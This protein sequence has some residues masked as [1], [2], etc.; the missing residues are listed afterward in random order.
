MSEVK[1]VY[2]VL[3]CIRTEEG[4]A[5]TPGLKVSDNDSDFS[6]GAPV[7]LRC[8]DGRTIETHVSS[9]LPNNTTS[10]VFNGK[11]V[12]LFSYL[13]DFNGHLCSA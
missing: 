8:P 7:T 10:G 13:P 1:K 11:S 6:C 5:L 2:E 12:C 4:W 3:E 9:K